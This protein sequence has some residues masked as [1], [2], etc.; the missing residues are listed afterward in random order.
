MCCTRVEV[1]AAFA[2]VALYHGTEFIQNRKEAAGE[3]RYQDS[4]ARW[5]LPSRDQ[6]AAA[7]AQRNT[8]RQ[9]RPTAGQ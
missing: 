4:Y 8:Q 5:V 7:L 3:L 2:G 9:Q 1:G 6:I